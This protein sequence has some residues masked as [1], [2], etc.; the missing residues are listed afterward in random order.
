LPH[1]DRIRT[2]FQLTDYILCGSCSTCEG[3]QNEYIVLEGKHEGKRRLKWRR[4]EDNIK[5]DFQE[6]GSEGRDW[7][8]LAQERDGRWALVN[9]VMNVRVPKNVGNFFTS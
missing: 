5:M 7:I 2:E 4:W 6:V 1:R 8:Y 9:A 3:Q